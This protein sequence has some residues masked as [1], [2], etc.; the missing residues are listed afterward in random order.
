MKTFLY[1]N[2]NLQIFRDIRWKRIEHVKWLNYVMIKK[3]VISI[4]ALGFFCCCYFFLSKGF[5]Q[6]VTDVCKK[7]KMNSETQ[8]KMSHFLALA[9][10]WLQILLLK[11]RFSLLNDPFSK[12]DICHLTLLTISQFCSS[13]KN[14]ILYHCAVFYLTLGCNKSEKCFPFKQW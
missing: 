8:R 4:K 13:V 7:K 5:L 11:C 2:E 12:M 14:K 10:K 9:R 3:N 6:N 1:D